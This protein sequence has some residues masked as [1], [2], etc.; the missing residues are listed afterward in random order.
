MERRAAVWCLSMV[1]AVVIGIVGL[2]LRTSAVSVG[3]G[4]IAS[5]RGTTRRVGSTTLRCTQERSGGT[6][7]FVWR[8]V[9]TPAPTG[10]IGSCLVT[11]AGSAWTNTDPATY[12][13]ILSAGRS[14]SSNYEV[15][16]FNYT[17]SFVDG[18]VVSTMS[19]NATTRGRTVSSIV[20]ARALYRPSATGWTVTEILEDRGTLTI[21][22]SGTPSTTPLKFYNG[23]VGPAPARCSGD[24]L[25]ITLVGP[26]ATVDVTLRRSSI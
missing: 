7:R 15:E 25:V 12:A 9:S 11:G 21:D 17:I 2:P 22:I 10:S 16:R 14:G 13:V 18:Q 5:Q 1:V 26:A 4:C 19:M 23:A 6:T 24:T 3:S 8:R 20:Q